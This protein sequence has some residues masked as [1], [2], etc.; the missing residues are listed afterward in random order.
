MIKLATAG[1]TMQTS[2]RLLVI[3]ALGSTSTA[4]YADAIKPISNTL[5]PEQSDTGG[6]AL[7][8]DNGNLFM[9]EVDSPKPKPK[10]KLIPIDLSRVGVSVSPSGN[11]VPTKDDPNAPW[12]G[13]GV[14]PFINQTQQY[15][16][17]IPQ[18]YF[19]NQGPLPGT[20]YLTPGYYPGL[21]GGVNRGYYPG[22][23]PLINGGYPGYGYPGLN[24]Y[25]YPGIGGPGYPG[26]GGY[27]Y[28]GYG[29]Y[30]GYGYP[31]Y[32]GY[33]GYG[34][35]GY[36]GYG[37]IG[38]VPGYGVGYPG[39]GGYPLY[40]TAVPP[41]AVNLRLGNTQIGLGTNPFYYPRTT[42]Q[43]SMWRSFNLGF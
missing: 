25:G 11:I 35:G 6:Q 30:G 32:A 24:G 4:A 21:S 9:E 22:Y 40:N 26:Y 12:A 23:S 27:G 31:G 42:T 43:S 7:F 34:M 3:L 16:E 29:G 10:P 41:G 18:S 13:T 39:Y 36:P 8:T 2:L 20:G 28:P 19:Y 17:L 33:S 5:P 38:G 1:V 15:T 14:K 37:G